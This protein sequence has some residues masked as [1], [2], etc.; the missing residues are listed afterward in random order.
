MIFSSVSILNSTSS[1]NRKTFVL[2]VAQM[3]ASSCFFCVH[4]NA[5]DEAMLVYLACRATYS[6]GRLIND[7]ELTGGLLPMV[8]MGF[9]SVRA[10]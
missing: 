6:R 3:Y 1:T 7:S 9:I 10:E 2:N 5:Y 8:K 4:R